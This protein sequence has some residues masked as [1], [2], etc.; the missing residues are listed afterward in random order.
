MR[1]HTTTVHI[2]Y[3]L[4]TESCLI[5]THLHQCPPYD[6]ER[7]CLQSL[8]NI[9][10][11]FSEDTTFF[12]HLNMLPV[13]LPRELD[14]TF[15]DVVFPCFDAMLA[16]VALSSLIYAAFSFWTF[17]SDTSS[18][19]TTSRAFFFWCASRDFLYVWVVRAVLHDRCM[20]ESFR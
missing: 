9:S 15:A 7:I 13:T 11:S 5:V 20:K 14:L 17:L 6:C 4:T 3:L 19:S 10:T 8:N 16:F 1:H 18:L 2:C 12:V